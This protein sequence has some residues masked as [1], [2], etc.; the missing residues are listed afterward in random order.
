MS[1]KLNMRKAAAA[2]AASLVIAGGAISGTAASAQYSGPMGGCYDQISTMCNS[3]W[4]NWGYSSYNDCHSA[5]SCWVCPEPTSN[6]TTT[7]W[8]D[9]DPV[10]RHAA[11]GH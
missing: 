11:H 1:R 4:Q 6:C 7:D 3:H 5:E 9:D 8:L 2:L 10:G